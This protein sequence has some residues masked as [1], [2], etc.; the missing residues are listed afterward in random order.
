[1]AISFFKKDLHCHC[2]PAEGGRGN[3]FKKK[4][5]CFSNE[6]NHKYEIATPERFSVQARNDKNEEAASFLAT[7]MKRIED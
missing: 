4:R 6:H 3:L 2:E 1:V 7:T 5:G